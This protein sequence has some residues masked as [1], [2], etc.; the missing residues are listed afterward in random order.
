[1][2]DPRLALFAQAITLAADINRRGV[3]QQ[4]VEHGGG[5]DRIGNNVAPFSI[6]FVTGQQN[7]PPLIATTDQPKQELGRPLIEGDISHLI[8]DQ[9]FWL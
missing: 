6:R 5:Q 1:M 2:K 7:A 3:M 9:Q 8:E 4:P